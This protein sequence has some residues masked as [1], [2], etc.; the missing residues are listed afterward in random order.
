MTPNEAMQN[1]R[2]GKISCPVLGKMSV[3]EKNNAINQVAESIKKYC[4]KISTQK[5]ALFHQKYQS[6]NQKMKY[7]AR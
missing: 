6:P 7:S 3:Q 4:C 2:E 5:K 1:P